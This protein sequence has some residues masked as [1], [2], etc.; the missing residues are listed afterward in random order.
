MGRSGHEEAQRLVRRS[1]TAGMRVVFEYTPFLLVISRPTPCGLRGRAARRAR[2]R[3]VVR[4]LPAG[5]FYRD[6]NEFQMAFDAWGADYPAASNF[7]TNRFTCDA[8]YEPPTGFCDPPIDAMIDRATRM[9][10][11]TRQPPALSGRRSITRS[12]TRPRTSGSAN[13]IAV[14]FV[15]ERVGNYQYQPSMGQDCFNQLWV[16]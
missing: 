15:S 13:P 5:E 11:G 16:R 6:G 12:S 10:T 4:S 2:L 8:S 14:E 3:G 9:Q 7:I 1:G